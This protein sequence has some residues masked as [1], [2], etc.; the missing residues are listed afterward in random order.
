MPL[1]RSAAGSAEMR[2]GRRGS[3]GVGRWLR[4]SGEDTHFAVTAYPGDLPVV[5]EGD[6]LGTL[7]VGE[8][9]GAAKCTSGIAPAPARFCH[10][11][12][13]QLCVRLKL[14]A[15][16]DARRRTER[17]IVMHRMRHFVLAQTSCRALAAN[18]CR[19]PGIRFS[20]SPGGG[21]KERVMRI[22]TRPLLRE[23]GW[24]ADAACRG[25]DSSVFFSPPGERGKARR[26]RE[27]AART[28]CAACP[29]SGPCARF[30][31]AS[32]QSYGTWGGQ[33]ETERRQPAQ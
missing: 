18:S 27:E 9:Q 22:R 13:G 12:G 26:Q 30:A 16:H 15:P 1:G 17:L 11:K 32:Q 23:W 10:T 33:S 2:L 25:M 28:V 7:A 5:S 21:W 14:R 6:V 29:V 20:C 19:P 8:V 31:Q 3:G 4:R 24:Q